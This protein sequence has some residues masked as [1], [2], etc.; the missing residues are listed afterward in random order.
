MGTLDLSVSLPDMRLSPTKWRLKEP[1]PCAGF[2]LC[3]HVERATQR[4]F[5]PKPELT[6]CFVVKRLINGVE[7]AAA[8]KIRSVGTSRGLVRDKPR[9]LPPA[10][11]TGDFSVLV[12]KTRTICSSS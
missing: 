4:Q 6:F 12:T 11:G 7:K 1:K 10:P 2:A 8:V 3:K 9:R 5:G